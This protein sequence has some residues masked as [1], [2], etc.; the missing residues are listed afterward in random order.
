MGGV[1]TDLDEEEIRELDAQDDPLMPFAARVQALVDR[2]GMSLNRL[3]NLA[4]DGVARSGTSPETLKRVR[5]GERTLHPQLV[6][7]V[8]QALDPPVEP[9]L[10]PEYRLAMARQLFDERL[11][12][13][14]QALENLRMLDAALALAADA[15]VER[16]AAR[17]SDRMPR[18]LRDLRE[19]QA[20]GP[21]ES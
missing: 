20:T 18:S 3:G 21:R 19:A 17:A 15:A 10:F 8:A 12:G 5:A 14:D 2:R 1:V 13:L 6:R 11:I 4:W 7:A 16:G 9:E